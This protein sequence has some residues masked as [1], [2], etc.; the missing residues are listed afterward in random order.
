MAQFFEIH[1]ANPQP[2]LVRGAVEILRNAGV[3]VYPT[4]S[5]YALGCQLGAKEAM[6][7]IR[8]IRGLDDKHNFTLV[9][10]DLSEI[11]TYARIDN[12]AFRTLKGLTPG[13]YTFIFEATK[14]VPRRMLHPKRKGIGIR[15]PDN[16]ICRALLTEL[17]EP[18]LSAT[19]LLPGQEHPMTDPQ[20]MRDA[21][22]RQVDLI[23]DGGAGGM[24]PSTVVDMTAEPYTVVRA[25]LGDPS[26][27]ES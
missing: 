27:F 1:P 6:E 7:R 9:C 10:R 22:D 8:R 4:D 16:A 11:T 23:V 19:L 21:L 20:A 14:Q 18:I 5:S 25:G 17:D 2:R 24:E 13:P 12:H 15:V 3:I 26:L